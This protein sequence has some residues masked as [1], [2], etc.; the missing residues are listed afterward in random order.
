VR[1][2]LNPEGLGGVQVTVRYAPT[3]EVELHMNVE[4]AATADLVQAGWGELRDALSAQGISPDR[5]VM[6]IT[7]SAGGSGLSDGSTQ[8]NGS[9]FRSD[10]GQSNSGQSGQSGQRDAQSETRTWNG[11][12]ESAATPDEQQLIAATSR[13]DL[14]A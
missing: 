14:R 13:I 12:F 4:H 10:A 3:G 11:R 5:L 9:T 1:I 7:S 6:S 2:E 8:G